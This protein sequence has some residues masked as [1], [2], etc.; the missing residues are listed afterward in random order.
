MNQEVE[1][2]LE[3][4]S[5]SNCRQHWTISSKRHK[6]Q[7]FMTHAHLNSNN[8]P[9]AFP[10]TITLTRLSPRSL[11]GDNLQGALKYIR[12]SVADY[13]IPGLRPGRADDDKR[14]KWLYEQ[15]KS[16]SKMVRIS[17]DYN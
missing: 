7:K 5:E 12:D 16:K 3:T 14:I 17:F 6:L 4:I 15:E 2:E 1:F 10:V 8:V 13:F 11:D 9:I